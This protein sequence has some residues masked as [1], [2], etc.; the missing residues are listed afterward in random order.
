MAGL[1]GDPTAADDARALAPRDARLT[2]AGDER[3]R[4]QHFDPAAL[5]RQ[6]P[7]GLRVAHDPV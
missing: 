3:R 7:A 1:T 5:E 6:L 2:R 4:V